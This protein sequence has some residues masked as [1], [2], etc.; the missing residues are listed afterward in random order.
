M[1]TMLT[2]DHSPRAFSSPSASGAQPLSAG[3]PWNFPRQPAPAFLPPFPPCSGDGEAGSLPSLLP[4]PRLARPP[5]EASPRGSRI[6]PPCPCSPAAGMSAGEAKEYLARREIPQLFE[7]GL[8]GLGV[9]WGR[10]AEGG[11][12]DGAAPLRAGPPPRGASAAGRSVWRRQPRSAPRPGVGAAAALVQPLGR[13]QTLA[14]CK[15]PAANGRWWLL[16]YAVWIYIYVCVFFRSRHPTF[17]IKRT[18]MHFP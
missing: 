8:A 11:W 6:A 16:S 13:E 5:A 12:K 7:V 2:N 10:G 18:H 17:Y 4:P 14:S 3:T 9:Y 1:V 15:L